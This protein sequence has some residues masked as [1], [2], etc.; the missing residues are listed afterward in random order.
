MTDLTRWKD[1]WSEAFRPIAEVAAELA[2]DGA[3]PALVHDRTG[4]LLC[5]RVA[6][7][8]AEF[9]AL[10]RYLAIQQPR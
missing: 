8:K 5:L 2:G 9:G 6:A 1:A 3:S 7:A 10:C 4:E